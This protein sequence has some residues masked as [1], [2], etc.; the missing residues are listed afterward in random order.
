MDLVGEES[1][2]L[3]FDDQGD[4]AMLSTSKLRVDG[5]CIGVQF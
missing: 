3:F 2:G 5:R 4:V 1:E